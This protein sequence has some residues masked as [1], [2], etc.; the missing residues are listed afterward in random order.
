MPVS[1]HNDKISG[2][3]GTHIHKC[4]SRNSLINENTPAT[5]RLRGL[6]D[7]AELDDYTR[8]AFA[9]ESNELREN[10]DAGL[11]IGGRGDLALEPT[12]NTRPLGYP[13]SK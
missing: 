13:R 3:L 6:C 7:A 4:P 9:W 12:T 5:A 8:I 2:K 10:L 1:G 11:N